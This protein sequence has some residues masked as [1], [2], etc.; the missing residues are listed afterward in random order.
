MLQDEKGS[1]EALRYDLTGSQC[2]LSLWLI[3]FHVRI[4]A[5]EGGW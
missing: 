3:S 5:L 4:P 2:R 1:V